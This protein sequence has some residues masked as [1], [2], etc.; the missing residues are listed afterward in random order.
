[1]RVAVVHGEEVVGVVDGAEEDAD[2]QRDDVLCDEQIDDGDAED[3]EEVVEGRVLGL[4]QGIACGPLEAPAFA[5]LVTTAD[6]VGVVVGRRRDMRALVLVVSVVLVLLP[7]GLVPLGAS[8]GAVLLVLLV[9]VLV[10]VNL[11][12]AAAADHGIYRRAC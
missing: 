11:A 5:F 9:L 12:L 1:M 2:G 8:T 4:V 6:M 7:P 3:V 10:L